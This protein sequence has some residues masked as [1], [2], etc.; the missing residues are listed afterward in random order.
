M[1]E[2]NSPLVFQHT[3]GMTHLRIAC[4]CEYFFATQTVLFH[5]KII[6]VRVMYFSIIF[7]NCLVHSLDV[8]YRSI[9][10]IWYHYHI[11]AVYFDPA[12]SIMLNFVSFRPVLFRKEKYAYYVCVSVMYWRVNTKTNIR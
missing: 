9:C 3:T 11:T 4:H 8:S 12:A 6:T 1:T 5:V 2:I 7:Q 10:A